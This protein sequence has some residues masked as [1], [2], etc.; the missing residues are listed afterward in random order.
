MEMTGQS[1]EEHEQ[2]MKE[3]KVLEDPLGLIGKS[4]ERFP[5]ESQ[6]L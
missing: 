4:L 2:E 5:S 1:L 3:A 6:Y